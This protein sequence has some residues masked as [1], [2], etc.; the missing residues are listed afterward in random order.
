MRRH[1]LEQAVG[2][3]R[4]TQVLAAE[5]SDRPAPR[6]PLEEA[7]L[8][9]IRLVDVLDRVRLLSKRNRE[10]RET[11]GAATELVGHGREQLAICALEARLVDL[12]QLERLSRDVEGDRARVADLGNVANPAKDSVRNPGRSASSSCDLVSGAGVDLDAEDPRRA[13]HDRRE[14]LPFV[15]PEPEGHPETVAERRRE[16]TG[17]GRR[18]HER[19]GREIE[20]QRSRPGALSDDDVE[21]EVLEG[22]VQDLLDGAV[23]PVDLVHEE[24]IAR[25]EARED[26]SHVPLTLEGRAR[27]GADPDAELL[28]DDRRERRLTEPRGP[29]EEDVVQGISAPL[30]CLERDVQ[31]LLDPLLPDEVVE[32]TRAERL[33]DLLLVV[34]QFGR[35][36]LG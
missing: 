3:C 5:S 29:D 26:R 35:Q 13:A 30:G 28:A 23:H 27:D 22:R 2:L 18:P 14:L 32:S 16:Q 8:E 9:E 25:L 1:E 4:R 21:P 33:L 6:R 15:V 24:D 34:P 36:K 10:R 11:H 19:E 20:S 31:L 17:A 7:E 12:Q